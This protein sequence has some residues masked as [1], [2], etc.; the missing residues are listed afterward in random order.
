MGRSTT[1]NNSGRSSPPTPS[2][3]A[4]TAKSSH[5]WLAT[6][7]HRRK[8]I[9]MLTLIFLHL[10]RYGSPIYELLKYIHLWQVKHNF[11]CAKNR[12]NNRMIC[13]ICP[14]FMRGCSK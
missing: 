14:A 3:P 1:M 2:G 8:N 13:C 10:K 11:R 6:Y 7:P 4:A 12:N 9:H 5:T